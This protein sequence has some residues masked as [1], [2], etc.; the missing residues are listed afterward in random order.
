[1]SS[2]FESVFEKMDEGP[3]SGDV[4]QIAVTIPRWLYLDLYLAWEHD[5]ALY[6]GTA[7]RQCMARQMGVLVPRLDAMEDALLAY[8]NIELQDTAWLEEHYTLS[9]DN[10]VVVIPI[11]HELLEKIDE[12]EHWTFVDVGRYMERCIKHTLALLGDGELKGVQDEWIKT[13]PDCI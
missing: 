9:R 13:H 10:V 7:C 5:M 1:M 6:A 12:W 2:K 11:P 8:R 4:H 3:V